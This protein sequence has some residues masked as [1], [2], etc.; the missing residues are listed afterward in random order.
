ML[1]SEHVKQD[2]QFDAAE[3]MVQGIAWTWQMEDFVHPLSSRKLVWSDTAAG[4]MAAS[5]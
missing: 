5:A 3:G 2:D 1:W 4:K